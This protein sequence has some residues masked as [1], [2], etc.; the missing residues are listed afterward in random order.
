MGAA[1][2]VEKSV[3]ETSTSLWSKVPTLPS[4]KLL[5]FDLT[6]YNK[7]FVNFAILVGILAI[8]KSS[9]SLAAN[10]LKPKNKLPTKL[11]L[12]DKYGHMSWAL[13][14]D[15]KDNEEYCRFLAINGFNL[16]LMGEESD[17]NKARGIA[18]EIDSKILIESIP[19]N[20]A[21]KEI[22]LPFYEELL[23]RLENHDVAFMVLPKLKQEKD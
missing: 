21:E 19:V 22:E 18:E 15:C 17:I 16:I 2:V 8:G 3:K 4:L 6:K 10:A 14:T 1:S 12:H 23:K 13:I 5:D 7:S 9:I 20:W 11:Q